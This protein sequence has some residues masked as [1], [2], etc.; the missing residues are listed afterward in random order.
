M[1]LRAQAQWLP[2]PARTVYKTIV[3]HERDDNEG[4]EKGDEMGDKKGDEEGDEEG[5]EKGASVARYRFI[6]QVTIG[7]CLAYMIGRLR[8]VKKKNAKCVGRSDPR[9]LTFVQTRLIYYNRLQSRL[10]RL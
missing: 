10:K 9:M 4:D 5:D 6:L 3:L 2:S 1:L 7:Y 8:I